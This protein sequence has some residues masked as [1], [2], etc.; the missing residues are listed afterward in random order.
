MSKVQSLIYIGKNLDEIQGTVLPETRFLSSCE[1]VNQTSYML[2]KYD[3]GKGIDDTT[4][5]KGE[6]GKKEQVAS[7]S[8]TI[9][10]NSIRS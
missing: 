3:G 2:P 8:K 10:A 9:Q 4:F 7:K 5:Q 6:I 1:S